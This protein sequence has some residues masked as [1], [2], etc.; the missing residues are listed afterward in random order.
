MRLL[1]PSIRRRRADEAERSN[2]SFTFGFEH[3]KNIA[4][5]ALSPQGTLLLTVDEGVLSC[6]RSSLWFIPD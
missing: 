1:S 6:S 4:R 3:R 2:K 5:I